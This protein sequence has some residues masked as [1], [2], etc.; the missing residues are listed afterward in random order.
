MDDLLF[1]SHRIHYPPDKGDKSRAWHFLRHLAERYRVHLACFVATSAPA[2]AE[3][4]RRHLA[5]GGAAIGNRARQRVRR[6]FSWQSSFAAHLQPKRS[7]AREA[8]E[9]R[10]A[11]NPGT[12]PI[13]VQ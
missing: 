8:A 13:A 6:D 10:R 5:E 11:A 9:F 3:A 12:L 7:E 4:I 1:L 2:F